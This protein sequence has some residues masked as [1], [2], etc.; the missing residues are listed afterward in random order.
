MKKST[1]K[2]ITLIMF[3]T[4]GTYV[5]AQMPVAITIEP[6]DATA[7]DE[8]TLTLDVTESC[9]S[10]ALFPAGVVM[11]HSG[12]TI[13]DAAWQNVVDFDGIGADGTSPE[14]TPATGPLPAAIS[15]SPRYAMATDTITITLDTR[16]SC[17]DSS[18]LGADSIKIHSGVTLDGAGWS[19]VIAF[20]AMGAN[21]QST[22][23]M[24]NGDSTW[25]I[26]LVPSEFYGVESGEVTA[27]NCVFNG[28]DW[29][30]GEAKDF[31]LE[32]NCMDFNI[33]LATEY[34]YTWSIVFMPADY[35]GIEEGTSVSAINC[36]F[37]GGAWD[38]G[39]GKDFE[40]D[41]TCMDFTIPLT[42][43][44]V[45]ENKAHS[46]VLYPNP[47]QNILTVEKLDGANHVEVYNIIGSK[48]ISIEDI[49][50]DAV[51]INTSDLT[52]GVYFI[53]VYTQNGVQTAK[54]LKD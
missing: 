16:L 3:L 7:W 35:Y 22:H 34:T 24:N 28:G 36:V 37:N 45:G 54:F 2:I 23:L 30:L 49:R 12:V 14:L 52:P 26:T 9:P 27:I 13:D 5:M 18:L 31:D 11:I 53:N 19:N 51:Q 21:G 6:E 29:P 25:T 32:G 42:V 50:N 8:I 46:L 48:V 17:P 47:V 33:P 38:L 44:S 20:D 43:S 15:M 39:E 40:N 10:E 4:M 41:S 1:F